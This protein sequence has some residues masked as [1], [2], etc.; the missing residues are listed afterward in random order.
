[1]SDNQEYNDLKAL[2][3]LYHSDI[4][5]FAKQVFGSTLTPKQIEFCEAFRTKRTITFRGGV[6]FGKTHAEAIVTWWSLI[7]HDA[8]QVTIFGPSEP[9][10]RGGIWKELQVLYA[11]MSPIFKDSFDVAAT[12][13]ARKINGASCF[14]EYRL[15]SGDKPD[16]ARGIHA[17]NNFV[18]VDE[19]SG[20]DDEVYTGALLNILTDPNA[21]LCLVSNPSKASGFFWRTHCDPEIAEQWTQ[22]HGQMNDSPHFNPETFEQLAKNYG[23]P[24]S[25]QYRVMVLGEFP[26]SDVDGL[27]SREMINFAVQNTEFEPSPSIPIV[28]GLDVAGKGSDASVLAIRHDSRVLGFKE[29]QGLDAVRLAEKISELYLMTPKSQRPAVIA[30]DATGFG[31]GYCDVLKEFGLPIYACNFAGTPTRNPEKYSRVRDQIW[32]EMRDWIHSESVQIPNEPK[33]IED[34]ATAQYEDATGRIKLED[35]K[36]IKKR[37]GRSPDYGD[38]LALT[39]AVSRSR[40]ASKYAWSKPLPNELSQTFE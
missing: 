19:A 27:I 5:I 39:F 32:V 33:L 38:A 6:G 11:R 14:A 22:V 8:V 34:L 25:R 18:L 28:W 36:F 1:M 30:V 16:N 37:L 23:G 12:R 13:I 3:D 17:T 15:A 4:A 26:L 9:Q 29:Y 35:K 2:L 40:F 7:T 24:T 20:I 31:S 10:I 21:K